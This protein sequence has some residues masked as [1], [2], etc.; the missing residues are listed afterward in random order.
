[1]R[2][3]YIMMEQQTG[4]LGVVILN[5]AVVEWKVC[6]KL[7]IVD[8]KISLKVECNYKGNKI[9]LKQHKTP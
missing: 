7:H 4:K 8:S 1:M 3:T 6:Q 5:R 2:S 9:K